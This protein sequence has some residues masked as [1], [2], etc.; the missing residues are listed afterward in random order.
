MV[1]SDDGPQAPE[2][3][4]D[5]DPIN[6]VDTIP[7]ATSPDLVVKI[8][9]QTAVWLTFRSPGDDG[10]TGQ[11]AGYD[12]RY[13]LSTITEDNWD[14]ATRVDDVHPPK[15]AN[16]IEE[17]RVTGLPS[18]ADIYFALKTYD[19]VPN[20]SGLSNCAMNTTLDMGPWPVSDL[21]A[22]AISET[23]FLLTWTATGDDGTNGTATYY[24][25]RYA[26]SE[27]NDG[28]WHNATQ[29]S[30]EPPPKT[31]GEPESLLVTGL[32]PQTNYHFAVKVADEVPN[33][34]LLSNV[35]PAFAYGVNLWAT[36][37]NVTEGGEVKITYRSASLESEVTRINIWGETG[38]PYWERTIIRHLVAEQLP[39]D[40]HLA[41][42]DLTDDDGIPI[43]TYYGEMFVVKLTWGSTFIDS[44]NVRVFPD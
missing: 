24:D 7:P 35:F 23:E 3:P 6:T 37:Q 9:T 26:R 40:V 15:P 29:V 25:I 5:D 43:N 28:N 11:A 4:K 12:L 32:D 38:W 44:I 20:V 31:S 41:M 14:D 2:K 8:P 21:K 36:P 1:C 17:F 10:M 22:R 19:E 18:E 33:W 42:W 34:S 30:G 39:N 27:I 13:S 16:E